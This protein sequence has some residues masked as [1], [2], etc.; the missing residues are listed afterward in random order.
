MEI[1]SKG[2]LVEK[3]THNLSAF[4]KTQAKDIK[5]DHQRKSSFYD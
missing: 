4:A 1:D 5:P 3:K 2:N